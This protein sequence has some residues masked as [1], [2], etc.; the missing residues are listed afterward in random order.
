MI[1]SAWRRAVAI[2][3]RP[4]LPDSVIGRG[5]FLAAHNLAVLYDG[6][7]DAAQAR[8]WRERERAM[9]DAASV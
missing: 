8:H 3:E 7:R 6:L 4:E 5:S 9:R 2:G 1:E